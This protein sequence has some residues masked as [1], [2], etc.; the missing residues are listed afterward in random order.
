MSIDF[1]QKVKPEKKKIRE[2]TY[3]VYTNGCVDEKTNNGAWAFQVIDRYE[4][5]NILCN[6]V[7]N[8][9]KAEMD[10][11]SILESIKWII[12]DTGDNTGSSTI[13]VR[14]PE[15]ISYICI[16]L[17]STSIYC[18]NIIREWLDKWIIEDNFE[19]RPNHVLLR[20]IHQLIKQIKFSIT[21]SQKT[22][23]EFIWAVDRISNEKILE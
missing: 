13:I 3:N 18:V 14:K 17:Y 23:N 22:A 16:N 4:R 7:E 6:K 19:S 5:K 2:L 11:C 20:E 1:V 12:K 21:W 8:T 15:D 10:L 9:T